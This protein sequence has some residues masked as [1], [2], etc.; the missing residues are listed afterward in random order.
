MLRLILEPTM[1]TS[2]D[3]HAFSP[4]V[5]NSV[6]SKHTQLHDIS[7]ALALTVE[8]GGLRGAF[9]AGVLSV[10]AKHPLLPQAVFATS[11]GAPSAAYYCTGQIEVAARIWR[12]K[13][14]PDGFASLKNLLTFRPIMDIDKLV[15]YF[16]YEY[17]LNVARLENSPSKLY[18][19]VTRSDN[20]KAEYHR[21]ESHNTFPLLTATMALPFAFGDTVKLGKYRYVD[22][23]VADSIPYLTAK[24]WGYRRHLLILT[25]P[26]GYRKSEGR[27][28]RLLS[29]LGAKSKALFQAQY[30]RN[31]SY[32]LD[33]AR[34]E[35]EEKAGSLSV[36]RPD[37]PLPTSRI[38]N[39]TAA[40]LATLQ[41]GQ[42]AAERWL[43][44]PTAIAWL[45][46]NSELR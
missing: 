36:I 27:A 16:R 25:R 23:G 45:N 37:A 34:I 18:V 21:A 32:N 3:P 20:G 10:L 1:S 46:P 14:G 12:E 8:G 17:P 38:S 30:E 43:G 2:T 19:S 35:A 40:I 31:K 6:E 28:S 9:S 4:T 13:T 29:T 41:A 42:K 7:E 39:N 26:Q 15:S 33:L 22:G 24:N 44:S 5:E 11:S